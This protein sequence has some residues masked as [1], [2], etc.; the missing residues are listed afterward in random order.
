MSKINKAAVQR[1][2]LSPYGEPL[3][4]AFEELE[5]QMKANGA[6]SMFFQLGYSAP[7][8]S[9]Q[10]GDLIPTVHLS[11]QQFQPAMQEMVE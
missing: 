8:D 11:L 7:G 10:I 3:L 2:I 6:E 4:K 1:L 5:K 9:L